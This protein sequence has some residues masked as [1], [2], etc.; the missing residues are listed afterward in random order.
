M[1]KRVLQLGACASSAP[2]HYPPAVAEPPTTAEAE[3]R[4]RPSRAA[5]KTSISILAPSY[6]DSS[7]GRAWNAIIAEFNK[8]YPD[9]EVKLQIEGSWD[10]FSE[11]VAARIQAG[12]YPDILNDNAFAA[13]AEAGI[14]YPIDQVV[15]AETLAAIEPSLLKN[16]V[17]V[18]GTQWA[19]P[20]IASARMM[21]Y[22]TDLFEQAGIAAAPKS[23]AE[24]EDGEEARRPRRRRQGLRHAARQGG[25]SA[26]VVPVAVGRGR[27]LGRR[28]EPERQ[29]PRGRRG[30]RPDAEDAQGRAD[31]A[32][33]S[34]TT[35]RMSRTCSRPASWA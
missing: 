6:A 32:R 7:E 8:T 12:D 2:S 3:A 33:S 15:S 14:L 22:N 18:D 16:G 35:A 21:A 31:P 26:R 10:G 34:R 28:R 25:G 1:N 11:K 5:S 4:P 19:A 30:L 29:H 23:W 24:L 17:G 20:D 9:V 13:S 27:H